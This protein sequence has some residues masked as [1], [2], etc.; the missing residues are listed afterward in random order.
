MIINAIFVN[1]AAKRLHVQEQ[2]NIRIEKARNRVSVFMK[3]WQKC[4]ENY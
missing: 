2:T 1:T 3:L 4:K